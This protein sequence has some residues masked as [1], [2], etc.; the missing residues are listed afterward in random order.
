VAPEI[1]PVRAAQINRRGQDIVSVV[2]V[3]MVFLSVVD[4]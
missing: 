2:D 1:R 3:F 4:G